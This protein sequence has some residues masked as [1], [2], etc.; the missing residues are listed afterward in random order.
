MLSHDI[1]RFLWQKWTFRN[2][3]LRSINVQVILMESVCFLFT[4]DLSNYVISLFILYVERNHINN[5][6]NVGQRCTFK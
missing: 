6:C 5:N 3:H 1:P 4:P 2:L